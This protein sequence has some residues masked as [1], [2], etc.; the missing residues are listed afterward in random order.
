MIEVTTC[1]F[2]IN[3]FIT[4]YMHTVMLFRAFST[5]SSRAHRIMSNTKVVLLTGGAW[6][7]G[8]CESNADV[9]T[10]G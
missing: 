2:V 9:K 8:S 10:M 6:W 5:S 3:S 1:R 7:D 4:S